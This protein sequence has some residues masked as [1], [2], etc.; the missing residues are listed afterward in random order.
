MKRTVENIFESHLKLRQEG[1]LEEDLKTNYAK[2]VIIITRVG[3]YHGHDGIRETASHLK[4]YIPKAQYSYQ[5]KVVERNAAYL[6][7]QAESEECFVDHGTD[8]FFTE[9]G[10]IKVQ[11]IY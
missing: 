8:T 6:I 3:T 10:E 11:T 9:E 4:R 2:D 1:K 7:W 5:K